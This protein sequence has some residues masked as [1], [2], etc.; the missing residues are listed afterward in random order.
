LAFSVLRTVVNHRGAERLGKLDRRRADAAARQDQ[1]ALARLELT[2][3]EREC[4]RR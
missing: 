3:L 1:H 4:A 2:A